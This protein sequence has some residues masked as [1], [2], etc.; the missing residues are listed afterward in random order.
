MIAGGSGLLL[1]SGYLDW[2]QLFG[3]MALMLVLLLL[4]LWRM[5]NAPNV[6]ASRQAQAE[7]EQ[8]TESVSFAGAF[9]GF[10]LRPGMF[11]WLFVLLTYKLADA[12][13][14]GM[15]KP[16]LVDM[17]W[18]SEA[19]GA[20]TLQASLIGM[21]GALVGGLYYRLV[22]QSVALLSALLLQVAAISSFYFIAEAQISSA[23]VHLLVAT[24]QF[25]DGLS[26]VVLFALMMSHCRKAY[27]GSDYTLQA[28]IQIVLAG[29]LGALSGVLA[30]ALSY[31]GLYLVC[32]LSGILSVAAVLVYLHN[33]KAH[34]HPVCD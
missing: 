1:L 18:S 29:L 21:L 15:L 19:I 12:L 16:M 27:A 32:A 2:P 22:G 5:V 13:G 6:D 20:L 14:S 17:A 8:V 23:M 10:V 33:N 11:A 25:V 31:Q 7:S 9:K 30:S 24:E 26:T 4:P 28:S 34:T 3:A